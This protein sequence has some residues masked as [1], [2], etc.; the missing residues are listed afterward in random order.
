MPE[1]PDLQV[2]SRNLIK[3]FKGKK[4]QKIYVLYSDKLNVTVKNLQ[5]ALQGEIVKNISRVG[6]ELHINFQNGRILG[7]H[8]MLHGQLVLFEE[9][10]HQKHTIIELL[11]DDNRGLGMTDYQKAATPTL[12][13]PANNT[14]DALDFETAYFANKLSATRR[15]IK[16]VLLD[17]KILRGIG[18]AYSDEILWNARISPLSVSNKIPEE[19]IVVLVKSIDKVLLNAEKLILEAKPDII[20]EEYR[21][22]MEVHSNQLKQTSTGAHIHQTLIG[23]RKTYYTDE[24]ELFK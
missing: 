24:Q 14:P 23:S 22:F 16:T 15:P 10:N 5:N 6:K 18:N 13:P 1:L 17:Q 2:F 9:N 4:L 8:L 20:S 7:L 19:K 3:L 12:D 11:F 21:D